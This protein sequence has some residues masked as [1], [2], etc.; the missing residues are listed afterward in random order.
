MQLARYPRELYSGNLPVENA[1][2]ERTDQML[3]GTP[4]LKWGIIGFGE[5]AE[6]TMLPA[7]A[8]SRGAEL[9]AVGCRS[10]RKAEALREKYPNICFFDTYESLVADPRIEAVYI[11][12]PNSMHAEWTLKALAA[13]KHVLCDKPL[14]LNYAEAISVREEAK[15]VKCK[16]LEGFMYRFHP[17]HAKVKELIGSGVIGELRL[18]EAHFHYHLSNSDDIRRKPELGGGGLYD[19]GCYLI[20]CSR[21]LLEKSPRA[22]SGVWQIDLKSGVD[23]S[24]SFQFDYSG[25]LC[26]HLTCGCGLVRSNCYRLY[27]SKGAIHVNNAFHVPRN[28]KVVIEVERVGEKKRTIQVGPCNQ[29]VRELEAFASWVHGGDIGEVF[30][31]DGVENARVSDAVR[32]ALGT[33]R[34]VELAL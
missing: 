8:E 2:E 26:A 19:V 3:E 33:S 4:P 25:G 29:Y 32:E 21:F 10:E 15:R 9:L 28:K 1:M 20:D 22:V 34:R 7:L 23:E 16:V 30:F 24:A 18:L 11:G 12:L 6:R 27:G 17:Q 14:A 13:A 5:H 31:G